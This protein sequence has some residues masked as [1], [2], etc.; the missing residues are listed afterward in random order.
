VSQWICRWGKDS[1]SL[2]RNDILLFHYLGNIAEPACGAACTDVAWISRWCV[3]ARKCRLGE[4]AWKCR[5]CRSGNER[6]SC[7]G[8]GCFGSYSDFGL[9]AQEMSLWFFVL[10]A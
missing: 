6:A 4:V 3:D 8:D 10:Q 1:G 9:V 7:S 5:E 2:H